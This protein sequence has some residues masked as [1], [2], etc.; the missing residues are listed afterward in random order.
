MGRAEG[1]RVAGSPC[2]DPGQTTG[3]AAPGACA[4]AL[5]PGSASGRASPGAAAAAGRARG[6]GCRGR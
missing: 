5:T 6:S 1:P 3:G 2:E 4:G